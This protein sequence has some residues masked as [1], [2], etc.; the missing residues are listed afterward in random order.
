MYESVSNWQR[1]AHNTLT[2]SIY[3]IDQ[4]PY[5][6]NHE[7]VWLNNNAQ[8]LML[9]FPCLWCIESVLVCV[10]YQ[11]TDKYIQLHLEDLKFW[12]SMYCVC[13]WHCSVY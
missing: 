4:S 2:V 6:L 7:C 5:A 11:N 12:E 8:G 10:V 3:F 13:L 1:I 9:L